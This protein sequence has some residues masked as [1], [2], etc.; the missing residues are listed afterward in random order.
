MKRPCLISVYEEEPVHAVLGGTRQLNEKAMFDWCAG[1]EEEPAHVA[2]G[3][4]RH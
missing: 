4:T 2:Q 3:G 1:S